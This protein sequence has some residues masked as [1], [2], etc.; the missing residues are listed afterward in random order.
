MNVNGQMMQLASAA[1]MNGASDLVGDK[2]KA[3]LQVQVSYP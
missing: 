1:Q 2:Y 3:Q